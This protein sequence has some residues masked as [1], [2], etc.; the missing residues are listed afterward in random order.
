MSKVLTRW[1]KCVVCAERVVA[2]KD[3][4]TQVDIFGATPA[5]GITAGMVPDIVA[6]R[7]ND[8]YCEDHWH[9]CPEDI[10]RVL[11]HRK[12]GVGS[13]AADQHRPAQ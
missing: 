12:D 4:Q 10:H 5:S 1:G 9:E 3:L 11:A 7:D 8:M 2:T 13:P 6:F